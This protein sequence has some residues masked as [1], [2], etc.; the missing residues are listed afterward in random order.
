M[1]ISAARL[2]AFAVA[3]A[4]SRSFFPDELLP[5]YAG[6]VR[7]T[8]GPRARALG[9][10]EKGGEPEDARILRPELLELG[11][12]PFRQ[13]VDRYRGQSVD[14]FISVAR[15]RHIATV[16]LDGLSKASQ[17]GF[18]PVEAVSVHHG[19]AVQVTTVRGY[20]RC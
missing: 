19:L 10:A 18:V 9:F 15:R 12:R 13:S 14:V 6:Y 3:F 7:E 11:L 16:P 20:R 17:E 4:R 2:S 1:T 8:F 5:Q